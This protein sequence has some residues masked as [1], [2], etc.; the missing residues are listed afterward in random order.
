MYARTQTLEI[1]TQREQSDS[2]FGCRRLITPCFFFSIRVGTF[3]SLRSFF[4]G[5]QNAYVFVAVAAAA[6]CIWKYS[7]FFLHIPTHFFRMEIATLQARKK[8]C[9][10]THAQANE[11][12]SFYLVKPSLRDSR[13]TKVRRGEKKRFCYSLVWQ[14]AQFIISVYWN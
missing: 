4:L 10:R 8:C 12:F 13:T 6:L 2:K 5:A 3:F 7:L 9:T 1:E 14:Y 11:K